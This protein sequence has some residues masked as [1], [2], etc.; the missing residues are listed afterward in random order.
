[1]ELDE[2]LLDKEPL[3]IDSPEILLNDELDVV[4]LLNENVTVKSILSNVWNRT[5]NCLC[6]DNNDINIRNIENP[7]KLNQY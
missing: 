1:M 6:S 2:F 5:M 7:Y 3:F 4:K